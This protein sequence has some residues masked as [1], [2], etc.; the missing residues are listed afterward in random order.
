MESELLDIIGQQHTDVVCISATPPAAAMHA[1]H[2][3]KLLRT[4]FPSLT[5]V[6]GLLDS[7]VD[8]GK[9]Q[10]R[11]GCGA[12]TVATLANAQKL[13]RQLIPPISNGDA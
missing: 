9:T 4:C 8:I 10:D 11:I 1:R 3:C 12:T 5:L 2:L 6:V 13:I 7:Q